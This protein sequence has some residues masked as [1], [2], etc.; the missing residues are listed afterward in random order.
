MSR[1]RG[2]PATGKKSSGELSASEFQFREERPWEE[3]TGPV[4][5]TTGARR[6]WPRAAGHLVLVLVVAALQDAGPRACGALLPLG[7]APRATGPR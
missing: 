5:V 7:S 1:A 3:T 4:V 2:R 6:P